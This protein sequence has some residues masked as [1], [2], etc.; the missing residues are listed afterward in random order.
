[1][2]NQKRDKLKLAREYLSKASDIVS[3]VLEEEQDCLDNMPDNLQFSDRYERME[4]AIGKLEDGLNSIEA[5]DEALGE[6]A[7]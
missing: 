3:D 4:V 6:A 2:N 1:M 5:A 7:N